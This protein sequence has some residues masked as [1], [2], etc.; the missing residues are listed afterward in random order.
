MQTAL[1]LRK[2]GVDVY[3]V[4]DGVASRFKADHSVALRQMESAG[5]KMTTVES[6]LLQSM[7]TAAHPRFKE[8]LQTLIKYNDQRPASHKTQ[9]LM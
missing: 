2:N 8:A 5:V 9:A 3:V 4:V 7:E 1:D 6:M